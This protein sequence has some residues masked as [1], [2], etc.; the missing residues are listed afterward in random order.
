MSGE[1]LAK[2]THGI[3][4]VVSATDPGTFFKAGT[5]VLAKFFVPLPFYPR[6]S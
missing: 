3:E 5:L 1:G 6:A 2:V 4:A